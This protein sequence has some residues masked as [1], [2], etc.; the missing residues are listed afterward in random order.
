MSILSEWYEA[1]EKMP[2]H[3]KL[4][5][6]KRVYGATCLDSIRS[7][8]V[9]LRFDGYLASVFDKGVCEGTGDYYV[10]LWKHAWG[11]P[12]Y[13]GSGKIDRWTD[14]NGRCDDF[15]LHLDA[16]DAVVYRV[17]SGVDSKT[18]RLYE[19]YVSANISAAGYTLAN[20]DNNA[21][22]KSSEARDRMMAR[23]K[24]IEG[25]D[26]TNRVESAVLHI[27]GHDP[28]CDYRVTDRFLMEYGTD[29]FSRKYIFDKNRSREG[30]VAV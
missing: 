15:Y 26:L 2:F 21:E 7:R 25:L 12:F 24:Q 13:V 5:M 28:G 8:A 1:V 4:G 14:K 9:L 22:Y 17:L 30:A 29:Y 27:V 23:C 11:D 19:R 18:A 10:Y 3:E 16:G 6:L 20:G